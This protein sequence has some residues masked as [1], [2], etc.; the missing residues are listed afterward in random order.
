MVLDFSKARNL[1]SFDIKFF[2]LIVI[3]G[4]V[5]LCCEGLAC[6]L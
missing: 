4:G 3:L 6:I 2:S 1:S 5:V